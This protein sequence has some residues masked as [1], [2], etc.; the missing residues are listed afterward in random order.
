MRETR[1][2][3]WGGVGSRWV[4]SGWVGLGGVRS[5]WG[6]RCVRVKKIGALNQTERK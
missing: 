5:G 4:G 1:K 6:Q 3:A 2:R